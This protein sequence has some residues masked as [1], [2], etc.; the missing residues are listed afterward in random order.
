M[1]TKEQISVAIVDDHIVVHDG[2]RAMAERDPLLRF[3]G[4]ARNSTDGLA[5]AESTTPDI[6]LIDMRL[7]DEKGFTLCRLIHE[8]MPEIKILIF[9]GFCNSEL[10]TQAIRAGATGY[11]LKDTDTERLCGV[12]HEFHANGSYF[13]PT[14][15]SDLLM[16]IAS[17]GHGEAGR[18]EP[19]TVSAQ[20]LRIIEMIASGATNYDIATE[21]NLSSNTVKFHISRLL[22]RF[23]VSRRAELVKLAME[24]QILS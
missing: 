14:L 7:A 15:S 6:L 18:I 3:V 16:G 13:D 9:S 10:L 12:L 1:N 11:V 21:L 17:A 2:I 22:R 19:P 24:R 4:G 8:R 5:L 20:D 23:G